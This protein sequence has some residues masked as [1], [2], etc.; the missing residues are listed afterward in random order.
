MSI[1]VGLMVGGLL[2]ALARTALALGWWLAAAIGLAYGV[3]VGALVEV[4]RG[5]QHRRARGGSGLPAG[6]AGAGPRTAAL[7]AMGTA[8][9]LFGALV[10]VGTQADLPANLRAGLQVLVLGTGCAGTMLGLLSSQPQ[11]GERVREPAGRR[12]AAGG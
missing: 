9:V 7:A 5:A 10:G 3:G 4:R 12:G 8:T 1:V 6:E 2:A 11:A